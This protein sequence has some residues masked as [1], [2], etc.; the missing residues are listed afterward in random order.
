MDGGGEVGEVKLTHYVAKRKYT[1][2][3]ISGDVRV[4][5]V[6]EIYDFRSQSQATEIFTN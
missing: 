2:Q 4:S 6:E 5:H 1:E 3:S